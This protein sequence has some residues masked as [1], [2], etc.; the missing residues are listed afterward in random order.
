MADTTTTAATGAAATHGGEPNDVAIRICRS[1][2][3]PFVQCR[4]DKRGRWTVA[5][6]T[7]SPPGPTGNGGTTMATTASRKIFVNLPVRDLPRSIAFWKHLGFAFD[8]QF[9]GDEGACMI[10]S[11][12]AF[13]MLLTHEHWKNFTKRAICDTATHT[14]TLL[15][16]SCRSRAEVDEIVKK[17]VAAGGSHALDPQDHGFMYG[18]SFYDPD[19]HHWEVLFLEESAVA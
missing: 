11:D 12:E 17:A 18:W 7:G 14:E 4:A 16:L 9:T 10:V 13:V 6:F 15:A 1:A 19:G 2:A 8:P 5:R 3:A